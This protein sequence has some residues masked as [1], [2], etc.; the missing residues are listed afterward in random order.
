M[1]DKLARLLGKRKYR[2]SK[3]S[4][5]GKIVKKFDKEKISKTVF[6]ILKSDQIYRVIGHYLFKKSI[7]NVDDLVR[8]ISGSNL[9]YTMN[10]SL[11]KKA[12]CQHCKNEIFF[13]KFD[14]IPNISCQDCN[15]KDSV[16]EEDWELKM[17]LNRILIYYLNILEKEK[18]VSKNHELYCPACFTGSKYLE[19]DKIKKTKNIHKVLECNKCKNIGELKW[20]FTPPEIVSELWESDGIWLEW[21]VKNLLLSAGFD[22]IQGIKIKKIKGRKKEEVEVD[23]ILLSPKDKIIS[24][25]CRTKSFNNTFTDEMDIPKLFPF[26]DYIIFVTTTKI[27][28]PLKERYKKL[29]RKCK[30]IYIDGSEIEKIPEIIRKL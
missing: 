10:E 6:K 23:G 5:S 28:E 24:I 11:V 19:E 20:F 9:E 30:Q 12:V 14:S 8:E 16:I 15:R 27:S 22:V 17:N 1:K 25:E 7:M 4:N 3:E 26:S 2:L 18:I 21:Y 13:A 29:S